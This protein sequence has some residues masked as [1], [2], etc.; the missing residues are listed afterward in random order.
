VDFDSHFL[1]RGNESYNRS[2]PGLIGSGGQQ[3]FTFTPIRDGQTIISA[4]YK[5]PWEDIVV[6][7]R[8]FSIIVF[9]IS[10]T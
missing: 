4:V 5:R 1:N 9:P 10:H 3:I 8:T 7:E 6:D 2:Q